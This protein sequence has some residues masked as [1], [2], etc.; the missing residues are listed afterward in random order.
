MLRK[1]ITPKDHL[2]NSQPQHYYQKRSDNVYSE[3]ASNFKVNLNNLKKGNNLNFN[4]PVLRSKSVAKNHRTMIYKNKI[5]QKIIDINNSDL[6]SVEPQIII[7][8]ANVS[9][10]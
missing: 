6:C 7:K 8:T 1:Y 10:M 3:Y 9:P 4:Q 2:G 5:T